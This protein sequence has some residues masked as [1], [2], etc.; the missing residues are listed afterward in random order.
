MLR[1]RFL[2]P[3]LAL[4]A[5]RPVPAVIQ[6]GAPD[7]APS[8]P[9]V[10]VERDQGQAPP[11]PEFAL[12]SDEYASLYA[13]WFES[14]YEYMF[15]TR[16]APL[17]ING[18]EYGM[19]M[20]GISGILYYGDFNTCAGRISGQTPRS[21]SD[22]APIEA[23]AGMPATQGDVGLPFDA[24]NPEIIMWA[25]AKLLPAPSQRISGIPAQIA[26]ERVFQ[27]FFRAMA[28]S[29]AWIAETR[30]PAA[31]AG[32]Y[33]RAVTKGADGIDWL[34]Q[35][36]A[37]IPIQDAYADGT[38]MTGPMAAGF[39]LRRTLDHSANACWYALV[40]V[41]ERYDPVWLGSLS[42]HYP[43]GMAALAQLPDE[44]PTLP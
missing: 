10:F 4:A 23:L 36:Y 13:C 15:E 32:D 44:A 39:W 27:R 37:Q 38:M 2:L 5:C 33:L 35:R 9:Q 19:L 34:E 41:L 20:A 21:Y 25:R 16:G 26:Y 22:Y 3:V 40:D 17:E 11:A 42:Q 31:E 6:V 29:L 12:I 30:D 24:V 14:P 28:E 7:P 18:R 1:A 43:Q 8:D